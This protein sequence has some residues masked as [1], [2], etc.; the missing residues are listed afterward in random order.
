MIM[1]RLRRAVATVTV[2]LAVTAGL[3]AGFVVS[4]ARG[5]L[6][7]AYR[8]TAAGLDSGLSCDRLRQWYV[9]HAVGQVTPWGWR[10]PLYRKAIPL[11]GAPGTDGAPAFNAALQTDTTSDTGTNVQEAGVDE[12][13]IVKAS[14][15]LL[16]RVTDGTLET[17][18][19]GGSEPR[20]LGVAL[21]DRIGDPQLLLAGDRAV[22]IGHRTEDPAA[23]AP[24][25]PSPPRTWVRTYD[26]GDPAH[27]RLVASRLY[28]GSLV[29]ARQVGSVVRLVL[30]GGPP[31]LD[32]LQPSS[33]R[34]PHQAL[35]HNRAVVRASTAS[36]WLP[37]VTTY[38]GE[39]APLLDCSDV[40]VP[41]TFTGLGTMTVVGFDPADPGAGDASA[42]AAGSDTAYLSPTHL[43]VASSP[44]PETWGEIPR[45]LTPTSSSGDSTHVY[46]FD[47][48]GTSASY[49][50]MASLDGRIAG[51]W[52]MDEHDGV[53]RVATSTTTGPTSTSLVMLRPEDGRLAVAG[54]L[55][56]LGRDQELRSVRW[57]DDL[58]VLVTFRQVDPFYVVD[59]ADPEAPQ[60]LG[61][62]HLPGWSSYLH[63]VGPHLVLGLGQTSATDVFPLPRPLPTTPLI[64]S[65]PVP[66]TPVP[67]GGDGTRTPDSDVPVETS[68]ASDDRSYLARVVTAPRAKATLFDITDPGHPRDVDT[69]TFPAG[70][71]PMAA[72]D[73]HQ[74]T[75]LPD[76]RALL[77]VL[78][79]NGP[80]GWEPRT[81]QP[82]PPA[83][84][85]ILTIHDGGLD[86]RVLPV[87]EATDVDDVRTLPLSDG[88]VVLVAGA[89]VRFVTV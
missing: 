32:F 6:D 10:T 42:V 52:S 33:T 73:P 16:V 49:V 60:V 13:D 1:N 64:P 19:V 45:P 63:P 46:G 4:D 41:E 2:P 74:V 86:D 8:L 5:G 69:V 61:E 54:R 36:D 38:A 29:T 34:T 48:S 84:L 35:A 78:S 75:W 12:P 53:L 31:P 21:L 83:W 87:P 15:D 9:G 81:T 59:V 80:W 23:G 66:P 76:R 3:V 55:D 77:T 67:D 72:T 44:S 17:Y 88:R 43:Y 24:L 57:F 82:E 30:G 56:G 58:A 40:S 50:G 11:V 89:A 25:V 62:L 22:V 70:S 7:P 47:L 20:R 28:D 51:S 27:P 79:G 71:A 18:D 68:P 85:S 26:L 39:P 65:L 14:G 37:Q